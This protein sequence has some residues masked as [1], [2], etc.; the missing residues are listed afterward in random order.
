MQDMYLVAH[1]IN[2]AILGLLNEEIMQLEILVPED[3][4][5]AFM[6]KNILK[7]IIFVSMFSDGCQILLKKLSKFEQIN[8]YSP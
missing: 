1:E 2:D 5:K 4:F 6:C 3:K 7:F 8:F